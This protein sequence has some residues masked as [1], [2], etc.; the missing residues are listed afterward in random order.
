MTDASAERSQT[1]AESLRDQ[2]FYNG[3]WHSPAGH[4]L[5][6]DRAVALRNIE[7][8]EETLAKQT[9]VARAARAKL[10]KAQAEHQTAMRNL[11]GTQDALD[12]M[13]MILAEKMGIPQ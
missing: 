6:P 11:H 5:N 7:T 10:D 8:Y 9:E 2:H 12:I 4:E 3:K 1:R 13:K